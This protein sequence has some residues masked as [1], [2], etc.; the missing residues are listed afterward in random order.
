ME[1]VELD[2]GEYR[3]RQFQPADRPALIEAF[4]DDDHQRYVL[5]YR[6]LNLTDADH[7]IARRAAEWARGERCSWAI[8]RARDDRL[9]GEVGL[10]DLDLR[11]GIAE[12]ALW[13]HPA[14]ASSRRGR[15]GAHHGSAVRDRHPRVTRDLLPLPR[16]QR[17]IRGGCPALRFP[18]R[19]H[20]RVIRWTQT[21]SL[22]SCD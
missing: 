1:P 22:P 4:A 2:A 19:R 14:C 20:P 18:L 17:G 7:Y 15:D 16:G 8:A 10:K 13:V 12:A 5:N 21:S 6:L 11:A 3:L 9:L